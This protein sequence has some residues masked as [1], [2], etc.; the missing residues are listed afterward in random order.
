MMKSLKMAN[1]QNIFW[2]ISFIIHLNI[3]IKNLHEI[4]IKNI[5]VNNTTHL[6]LI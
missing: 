2:D 6:L 4:N 5:V 1:I 3:R